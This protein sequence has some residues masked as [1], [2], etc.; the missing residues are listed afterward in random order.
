MLSVCRCLLKIKNTASLYFPLDSEDN[1][2]CFE[3]ETVHGSTIP[4]V[5]NSTAVFGIRLVFDQ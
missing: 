1:C 3:E 2:L 4:A 5:A